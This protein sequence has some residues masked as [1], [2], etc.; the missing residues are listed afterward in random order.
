V[1]FRGTPPRLPAGVAPGAG[2]RVRAGQQRRRR[3]PWWWCSTVAV[4]TEDP[5]A[6]Q[7]GVDELSAAMFV[8]AVELEQHLPALQARRMIAALAARAAGRTVY[9]STAAEDAGGGCR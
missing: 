3:G 8:D 2:L 9:R 7:L 1:R 5:V 4:L 6:L